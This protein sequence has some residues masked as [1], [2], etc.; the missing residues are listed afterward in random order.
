MLRILAALLLCPWLLFAGAAD[1]K[2][3]APEEDPVTLRARLHLESGVAYFNDSKYADAEREMLHAYE[4]RPVPEL[5]YN[6]AQ[7]QERL[8]AL[9]RALASYREYL[10]A[11][12]DAPDTAEVEK[13]V[14]DLERRQQAIAAEPAPAV[15][16][17]SV[18]APPP[19]P[20]RVVFKEMTVFKEP[21]PKAGRG[22]RYAALGLLGLT[23][24]GLATGIAFTIA[25]IENRQSISD[26]GGIYQAEFS[27]PIDSCPDRPRTKQA[28][29]AKAQK[30]AHDYAVSHAKGDMSLQ[31][32]LERDLNMK[33]GQSYGTLSGSLCHFWQ[34]AQDNE[35]LNITGAAIGFSVAGLAAI[36]SV[37]MLLYGLR[38]RSPVPSRNRCSCSIDAFSP[39][40][41][42]C[43]MR[44][45]APPST[46]HSRAWPGP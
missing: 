7:C 40:V 32:S 38:R 4:L 24:A 18:A 33:L 15:A 21:P 23:A 43:Q 6:L 39:T 17:E 37:G 3:A 41:T 34:I 13:R 20:E 22:A 19:P 44:T 31:M 26:E 14:A 5:K 46:R 16:A 42:P 27:V 10:R 28:A 8:G 1:A 30:D 25:V 36:G 9:D 11:R 12:P 29:M 2:K 45:A 35:T